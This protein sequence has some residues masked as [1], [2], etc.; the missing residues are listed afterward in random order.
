MLHIYTLITPTKDAQRL[1]TI[2]TSKK[3]GVAPEIILAGGHAYRALWDTMHGTNDVLYVTYFK[4][5]SL[6]AS[7]L[8]NATLAGW[9]FRE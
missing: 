9:D 1:S 8:N 5:T 3:D 4:C 7:D 2:H 6:R